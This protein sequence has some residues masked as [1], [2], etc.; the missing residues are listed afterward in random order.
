MYDL[1]GTLPMFLSI[2][3]VALFDYEVKFGEK[4]SKWS[5]FIKEVFG[6]DSP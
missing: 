3:D 6:Q 4:E 2:H 5:I 1:Y